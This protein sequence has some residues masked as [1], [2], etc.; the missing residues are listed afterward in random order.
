MMM[1]LGAL[2]IGTGVGILTGLFGVGGGFLITPLLN[3]ILGVPVA[4][5]V[6]TGAMQMLG[7]S[8]A[9]LYRR[10]GE[11]LTDY[12]MALVLF[13]GNYVGVRLG[14]E[15]LSWLGHL[16]S[17]RINGR[18]VAAAEIVVM[19]IFFVFLVA[20]TWWIFYDTAHNVQEESPRAGLFL[21][22]KLPPYTTFPSIPHSPLSLVV[23]SYF[24]LALGFL[25]GLLGIGGGVI[26]VPG[27]IYLV[28]MRTHCAAA[29]SLAMV[30]LASFVAT[31]THARLGNT[32]LS[33]A[34]PLLIGG[35]VGLQVGVNL[36]AKLGGRQLRRY[37]SLVVL[38]TAL[39][40]AGKLIALIF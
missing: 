23:M 30:W 9:G 21:R 29:T 38:L 12:K 33:L 27:L 1:I 37:F 5:A 31:I 39:L 19:G 16:G 36:C 6:G 8:T 28:G 20:I 10:R 40:V 2:L 13:G 14:A 15:A 3:V 25:T 32:D 35:S 4:V 24:G 7:V 34:I 26:L 17:W 18:E 11:S 22:I